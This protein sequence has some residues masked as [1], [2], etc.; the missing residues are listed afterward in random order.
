[1][2]QIIRG[3]RSAALIVVAPVVVMPLVGFSFAN[4]RGVLD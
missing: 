3:R 4:Q 1:M 2:V